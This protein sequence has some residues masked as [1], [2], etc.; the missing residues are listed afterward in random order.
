MNRHFCFT[1]MYQPCTTIAITC[2][3]ALQSV[4]YKQY[5][6]RRLR[7]YIYIDIPTHVHTLPCTLQAEMWDCV[8]RSSGSMGQFPKSITRRIQ[9]WWISLRD[10]T[11]KMSVTPPALCRYKPTRRVVHL[12]G[13]THGPV[14]RLGQGA[15]TWGQGACNVGLGGGTCDVKLS[16]DLQC[17]ARWGLAWCR[18]SES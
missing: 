15:E 3:I 18:V 14:N 12:D 16:G 9:T 4:P 1:D 8:L 11:W 7:L 17:R 13:G 10:Y 5:P 2:N 6:G